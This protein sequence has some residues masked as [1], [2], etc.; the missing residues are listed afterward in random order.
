MKR[1]LSSPFFLI[2]LIAFAFP[3]F[4]VQCAQEGFGD[5]AGQLGEQFGGEVTQ[6]ELQ[7]TVTGL[8][9]IT[10]EAEE[11]LAES[12]TEDTPVPGPTPTT[13]PGLPGDQAGAVEPDLGL[14][15]ILAIAAAAV[16]L[17]GIFL[18]LLGG[19]TGGLVA[20]ILGA[21]GA[22]LVFLLP[23]QF[24]SGLF[25]GQAGQLRGFIEVKNEWGYW[26][27]L[28]GFVIAA[29]TGLLRLLMREGPRPMPTGPPPGAGTTSGFGPPPAAPP[30]AAPPPAQ[31]PPPPPPGGPPPGEPP[32]GRQPP[33]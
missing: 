14:V 22:I 17:L 6:E 15:K 13:L 16:A 11:T 8:D 20:L 29:I 9:L 33:P 10:G 4:T 24:E 12:D 5:L 32:P 27:A 28:A 26:L 18:S 7:Q 3:F 31:P 23:G 25:G 19:R 1:F 21:I 30:P 2:A